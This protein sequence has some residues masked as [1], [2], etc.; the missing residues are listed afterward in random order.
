MVQPGVVQ[1]HHLVGPGRAQ[2]LARVAARRDHHVGAQRAGEQVG[3][4]R[5]DVHVRGGDLALVPDRPGE[6][7]DQLL[8]ARAGHETD[9]LPRPHVQVD[10]AQ[11]AEVDAAQ[12]Q[13]AR[14]GHHRR[15]ALGQDMRSVGDQRDPVR[16]GLRLREPARY[17]GQGR[18]RLGQEA[19]QPDHGDELADRDPALQRV[20]AGQHRDAAGQQGAGRG[21]RGQAR[22]LSSRRADHRAQRP[23]ADL[24]VAGRRGL[25]GAEP[26]QR[27]QPGHQVGGQ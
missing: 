22:A 20:P 19:G 26:A 12:P 24:P 23:L 27:P 1:G 17:D 3:L 14:L 16:R 25:L 21:R 15:R 8:P 9:E 11:R 13:L 10:A 18:E 4:V 2:R 6:Q 7:L 5:L